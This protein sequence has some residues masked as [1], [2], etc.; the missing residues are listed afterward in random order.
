MYNFVEKLVSSY[1]EEIYLNLPEEHFSNKRHIC[2]S[3]RR[4]TVQN[5]VSLLR[6]KTIS[7]KY[8]ISRVNI[9]Y[10]KP[11]PDGVASQR[12]FGNANLR[13]QTRDGWPN[14]VASRRKFDESWQKSYFSTVESE[15]DHQRSQAFFAGVGTMSW[16]YLKN[17]GEF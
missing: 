16:Q 13:T 4:E 8:F 9:C 2:K 7:L 17:R 14:G 15:S 12:K 1:R 10:L 3:A 5:Y 6:T 11:W